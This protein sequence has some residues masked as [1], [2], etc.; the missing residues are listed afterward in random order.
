MIIRSTDKPELRATAVRAGHGDAFSRFITC[1]ENNSPLAA[2]AL[3]RLP[4]GSSWGPKSHRHAEEIFF[5]LSGTAEVLDG[6]DRH[7]LGPHDAIHA[8]PREQLAIRNPGPGDLT[9]LAVLV[10]QPRGLFG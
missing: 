2:T 6:K 10:N 3:N 8:L 4:P 1:G 5:I 7:T 9:F